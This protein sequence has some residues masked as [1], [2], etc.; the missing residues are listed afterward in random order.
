MLL[1][2]LNRFVYDHSSHRAT[3][4]LL[5]RRVYSVSCRVDGKAVH[6]LLQRKIFQLSIVV[7]IIFLE[8]G[9]ETSRTGRVDTAESRIELRDIGTLR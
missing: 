1:R 8:N 4:L 9:D 7:R 3:I 2:W 6:H 5:L